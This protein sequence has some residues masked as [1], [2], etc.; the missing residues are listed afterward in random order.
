MDN[1]ADMLEHELED[2]FEVKNRGSLHRY[3]TLLTQNMILKDQNNSEHAA[4]RETIIR[5]DSRI[6]EGFKR[7][8]DRFEQ[9]ERRFEQV[10]KRFEQVDKRFEAMQQAMD[11]R[12]GQVDK[13]F[14]TMQQSMDKRFEQVDKRFEFMQH[15]MDRRFDMMFRFMSLGFIIMGTM[16]SVYQFLV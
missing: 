1:L 6:E 11:K 15:S 7:M 16:M 4:F 2:A 12:F 9:V 3:I 5:I 13:R 10:D 8:D 14:E